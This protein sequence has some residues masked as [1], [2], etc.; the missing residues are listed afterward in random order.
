LLLDF[1]GFCYSDAK[2]SCA[3]NKPPLAVAGLDLVITLPT[4]S[5]LLD[6]SKSSDP[7]GKISEVHNGQRFPVL[8]PF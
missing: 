6:A 3:S 7:D 1:A 2:E 5:R 4:D 8:L